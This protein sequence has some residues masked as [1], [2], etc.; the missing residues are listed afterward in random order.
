MLKDYIASDIDSVFFNMGEFAEEADINGTTV[1]VVED[2]DKLEY[3]IKKDYDGLIIGDVLF[4]IA[5]AEYEKIAKAKTVPTANQAIRYNGK[6]CT[7]SNV[8][9]AN[10]V[11]EII[12]VTAGG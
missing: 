7:I 11:Y 6:P 3:R 1:R 4:Y 9:K 12:L 2:S 8:N 5:Q 10:G